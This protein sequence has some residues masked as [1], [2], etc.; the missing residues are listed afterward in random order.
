MRADRLAEMNAR[1]RT[2]RPFLDWD[3]EP[4]RL[5]THKSDFHAI[6]RRFP[7]FGYI[8]VQVEDVPPFVM[9]SNNDDRVAQMYFWYGPNAFESLSL[10]TWVYLSRRSGHIFD[11]GAYTG[12]YSL[13]A[14]NANQEAEVYCFEPVQRVFGRLIDNLVVNRLGTKVQSFDVALS[15]LD[16]RSTMNL[17]RTHRTLMSGSS[18]VPKS[19]KPIVARE[20]VDILRLDTFVE[21]HNVPS[22]DLVK[23]DVEQAEKL[24]IEGMDDTLRRYGP[25]VLV[26]VSSADKLR[27]LVGMLSPLGYSFAVVDD[28][29][30][31]FHIDDVGAH[32]K[33]CNVLFSSMPPTEL[34]GLCGALEA[35]LQAEAETRPPARFW[36]RVGRRIRKARARYDRE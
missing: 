8:D 16:G 6:K 20:D 5:S 10:F 1:A 17:F 9:F 18:L 26:E 15:N 33:V 31:R 14:A 36:R 21:H 2:H 27:E 25:T 22:V 7:Y 11:I 35:R 13:A 30:Q 4:Q 24:V 29:R 3:Y 12:V 23:I 19:G 34:G 28:T 32:Q